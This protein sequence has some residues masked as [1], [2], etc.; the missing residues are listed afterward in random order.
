MRGTEEIPTS[1]KI[2]QTW[3]TPVLAAGAPL[4]AE[5]LTKEFKDL[6]GSLDHL[7]LVTCGVDKFDAVGETIAVAD[8]RTYHEIRGVV[9]NQEFEDQAGTGGKLAREE[10]AHA[11]ATDV[12]GLAVAHGA[13]AVEEDGDVHPNCDRVPLELARVFTS[14]RDLVRSRHYLLPLSLTSRFR[15]SR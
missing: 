4:I 3:G 11:A 15:T 14:S 10:Q 7:L 12:V 8:Y 13:L 6:A 1:G 9:R 2:G 5:L